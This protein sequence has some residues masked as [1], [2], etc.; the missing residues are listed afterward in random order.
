MAALG[1]STTFGIG[2]PVPH[3][4]RG[5]SRLLVEALGGSYDVSY[6]NTAAAGATTADVRSG[7][8]ADALAHRPDLATLV[9]GVNDILRSSWD[10][11]RTRADLM[12]CAGALHDGGA[13]LVTIRYH[14]HASLVGLPAWVGRPLSERLAAVN[15]AYDEAHA[16]YGGIRLDLE[17]RPELLDPRCWSVDRLHP[18]ERGHRA[19]ARAY[20][21]LLVERGLELES[22]AAECSGGLTRTWR[23]DLS[24]VVNE[25]A[26]WINRR[27]RDLGPW[28]AQLAWSEARRAVSRPET[29]AVPPLLTG[30]AAPPGPARSARPAAPGRRSGP[31]TRA[32]RSSSGRHSSRR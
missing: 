30:G 12:A 29:T 10:P 32:A 8:L 1:D 23:R 14:D 4:W 28:A 22:P 9:V 16:T 11:A 31:G 21:G 6:C 7:Q 15:L 26:P 25:G 24:W 3:G 20:A 5:W 19:L 2:D 17:G 18:S 13:V 27:A